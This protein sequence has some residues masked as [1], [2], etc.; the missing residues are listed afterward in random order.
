VATQ[1]G[2]GNGKKVKA[3]VHAHEKK[4]H[5]GKPLTKMPLSVTSGN[6]KKKKTSKDRPERG[7]K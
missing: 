6:G 7:L 4:M 5:P 3:G 1:S 2:T